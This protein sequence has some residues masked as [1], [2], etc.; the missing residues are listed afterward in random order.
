M[1]KQT[2]ELIFIITMGLLGLMTI[3]LAACGMPNTP[4]EAGDR[5]TQRMLPQ[6]AI[7][8]EWVQ[9][10]APGQPAYVIFEFRGQ[11]FLQSRINRQGMMA[12]IECPH[13]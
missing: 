7:V 12:P 10:I 2:R 11:C 6:G 9:T 1:N 3:L 13:G 8:R 5:Y 4:K